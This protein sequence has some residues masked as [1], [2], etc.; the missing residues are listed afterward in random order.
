MIDKKKLFKS[1]IIISLIVII[2]IA[3]VK[4][5]NTLAR[6][7]TTA[8]TDRDVDVAFWTVDNSF[9][10]DRLLLK[11]IQPSSNVYE[12]TFTVSNFDIENQTNIAE[13]DLEYEIVLTTTSNLP[14]SYE[15]QRNGTTYTGTTERLYEDTDGTW[16][17]EIKLGTTE[18]P[19]PLS[20]NTIQ[21]DG[22]RKYV[23]TRITDT[24]I[25]KVTFPQEYSA[26]Q[27][28]ADLIEYVKIDLS[29]RQ[30]ISE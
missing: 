15:I 26:N 21:D 1:L 6:Y 4:V 25:F 23:K 20:M 24:Y 13:T 29:A 3:A 28:Y 7:E 5:R 27:D 8:K 2:I 14:L 12:Y 11:D 10:S 19:F 9:K 18:N 17:R 30:V 22:T 16:Y